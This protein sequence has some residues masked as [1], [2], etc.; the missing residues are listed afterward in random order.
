[1]LDFR[2]KG[3]DK[4]SKISERLMSPAIELRSIFSAELEVEARSLP[5]KAAAARVAGRYSVTAR[6]VLAVV[7]GEVTRV[8]ADEMDNARQVWR[9]FAERQHARLSAEAA[10]YAAECARLDALDAE[11]GI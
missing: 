4:R 8:W 1:V 5:Q 2:I 3:P 11:D 6:R 7:H 10:K 9:G